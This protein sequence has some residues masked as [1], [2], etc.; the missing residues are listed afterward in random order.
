MCDD[1]W[2]NLDARV[3]CRQLGLPDADARAHKHA[4]FGEGAG[5][6]L[7]D[8][9]TCV[10]TESVLDQCQH[11]EWETHDCNH[12]E[13]VGVTCGQQCKIYA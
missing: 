9:V 12:R 8:N 2:D 13:D 5:K 11:S 6:I 10:G 3:V 7:L 4:H 1:K